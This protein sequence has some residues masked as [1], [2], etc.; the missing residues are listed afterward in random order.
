MAVLPFGGRVRP[1]AGLPDHRR[2]ETFVRGAISHPDH[3]TIHLQIWHRVVQNDEA[4]PSP[5]TRS[6]TR[7]KYFD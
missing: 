3:E 4:E 2:D 1:Q 7:V 6:F 5:L